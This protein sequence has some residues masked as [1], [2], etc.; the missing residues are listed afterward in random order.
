MASVVIERARVR[1]GDRVR[2]GD[3]GVELSLITVAE[4]RT[5]AS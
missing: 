2:I 4:V 1:A 3:P 5:S